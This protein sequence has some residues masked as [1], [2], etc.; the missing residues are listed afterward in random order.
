MVKL[1]LSICLLATSMSLA[2]QEDKVEIWNSDGTASASCIENKFPTCQIRINERIIDVTPVIYSNI[3]KLGLW[4]IIDYDKVVTEPIEW[5]ESTSSIQLVN[6]RT[7]AWRDGQR[8]TVTETVLIKNG[9]Y[10]AR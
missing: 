1:V 10:T 8:Y 6:F 2:A 3:G 7:Q 5:L 4:K 9:K